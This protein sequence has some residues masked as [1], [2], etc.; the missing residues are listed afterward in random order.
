MYL[1]ALLLVGSSMSIAH[2]EDVKRGTK[3]HARY[4]RD[5]AKAKLTLKIVDENDVPVEGADI[6]A[7]FEMHEGNGIEGTSNTSGLFAMAGKTRWKMHYGVR[8]NGYYSSSGEYAFGNQ[9]E[10]AVKDGKWQPW[11]PEVSVVLRPI[12]NQIPMY[13]KRV[14]AV[15]PAEDEAVGYDLAVGD[16]VSPYGSGQHRDLALL[17]SRRFTSDHDYEGSLTLMFTEKFDGVVLNHE[18]IGASEFMFPRYAT[19]MGYLS[20]LSYKTG[21]NPVS[22]YYGTRRSGDK[23]SYS[24]RIRSKVDKEGDLKEALYGKIVGP[25]RLIGVARKSPAKVI[26]T[27]YLNPTFNDLNLEFD[28]KKNLL[29]G[30]RPTE[31]V[32]QP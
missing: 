6:G 32:R 3:K 26:F 19:E 12:L 28:P 1:V 30:L 20:T 10:F 5:G 15:M 9:G 16:W 23:V 25:V 24:L 27:Y 31:V 21:E 4:L 22:G 11:N 13:A 18:V 14:E 8:K 7:H 29:K 2:G 17:L